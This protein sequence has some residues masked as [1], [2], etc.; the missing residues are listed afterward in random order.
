MKSDEVEVSFPYVGKR[1]HWK[2]HQI[3]HLEVLAR[4]LSSPQDIPMLQGIAV[5]GRGGGNPVNYVMD[6]GANQGIMSVLFAATWANA[7]VHALEPS[8]MNF[9]NLSYNIK[10]F[11]NVFADMRGAFHTP[12]FMELSLPTP[13]TWNVNTGQFSLYGE[14][15]V[16]E[17]VEVARLDDI[18]L[19]P[20]D[21]L[22]LDVEGAELDALEGAS[23]IITEDKP[24]LIMEF[25]QYNQDRAGRTIE[26][27]ATFVSDAGYKEIGNWRGD[28]VFVYAP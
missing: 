13:R 18:A 2:L 1:L 12:G 17:T 27:L 3:T 10:D 6:V 26:D 16:S 5:R 14:G 22:K 28:P 24:I 21:V 20:V 23:R 4:F 8:P 19:Q 15:K 7:K 25:R 9:E 11:P